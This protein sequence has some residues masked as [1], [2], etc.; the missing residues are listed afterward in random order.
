MVSDISD[1]IT[2][3]PSV[4]GAGILHHSPCIYNDSYA[5]YVSDRYHPHSSFQTGKIIHQAFG[6]DTITAYLYLA[7]LPFI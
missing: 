6:N 2:S 7:Q 3:S 4:R 5:C 1:C